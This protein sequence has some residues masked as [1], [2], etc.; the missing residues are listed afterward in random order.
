[1]A[2][3]KKLI[4]LWFETIA[5]MA[6]SEEAANAYRAGLNDLNRITALN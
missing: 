4:A 6:V 1:M 2:V 3:I 5:N